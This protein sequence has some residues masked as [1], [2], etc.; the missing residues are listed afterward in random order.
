MLIIFVRAI[1]LYILIIFSLR[2]MGKRQLGELQ[3]TELVITILISNL[4][5]LPIENTAIPMTVG[6]IPIMVLVACELIVSNVALKNRNFRLFLS[7][8]PIIVIS[9]GVVDQKALH[10]LRFSI[11]DLMESLRSQG[12]F[13][14]KDVHYAIVETTGTVS[15]L[16]KFEAQTVT[17][18]MIN[19]K[20]ENDSFPIV[21]ISDGKLVEQSLQQYNIP[22]DWLNKNLKKNK[23]SLSSVFLMTVDKKL[24]YYLV[25]KGKAN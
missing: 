5:S 6:I 7:G 17:P 12:V 13:D 16:Q 23:Q 11:D 9:E 3:P 15:V 25:P 22:M 2:L 24:E 18:K 10:K 8:R 19:L 1:F 14:I 20:G 4:A 21:V